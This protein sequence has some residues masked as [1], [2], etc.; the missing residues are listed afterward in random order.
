MSEQEQLKFEAP[1]DDQVSAYL[2]SGLTA[3]TDDQLTIV[4]LL[5]GLL[6]EFCG[7]ANV[8]VHQ[9][10]MHTHPKDHRDLEKEEV[11]ARDFGKVL[12]S[13]VVIALGDFASW[14]QA[15]SWCGPS[16]L[17]SRF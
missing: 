10:V 15:R 17:G 13:D 7:D 6:S 11:H 1:A 14:G 2:A 3:L 16:V 9:P 12:A 5:S 8:L 4:E